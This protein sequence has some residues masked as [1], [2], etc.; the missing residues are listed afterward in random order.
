MNRL[1]KYFSIFGILLVFAAYFFRLFEVNGYVKAISALTDPSNYLLVM[2]KI[3]KIDYFFIAL[4]M[5]SCLVS[6]ILM[7]KDKKMPLYSVSII[8]IGVA[9]LERLYFVVASSIVAKRTMDSNISIV[10]IVNIVILALGLLSVINSIL[11]ERFLANK[12][13]S[14]AFSMFGVASITAS[15]LISVYASI[16]NKASIHFILYAIFF[17]LAAILIAIELILRTHQNKK[18]DASDAPSIEA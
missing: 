8:P 11:V 7:N 12:H 5:V 2:G 10:G 17:L 1:F 9:I 16:V 13:L 4:I 14:F 6:F 15:T 3:Y 18:E